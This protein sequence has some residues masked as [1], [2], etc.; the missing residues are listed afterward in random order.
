MLP[1]AVR[2]FRDI[3]ADTWA[4]LVILAVHP[5]VGSRLELS[6]PVSAEFCTQVCAVR[7]EHRGDCRCGCRRHGRRH[8]RWHGP[9]ER[10]GGTQHKMVAFNGR[11]HSAV[12]AAITRQPQ[13]WKHSSWCDMS[14]FADAKDAKDASGPVPCDTIA[15]YC[16]QRVNL[17]RGTAIVHIPN[18]I[19]AWIGIPCARGNNRPCANKLVEMLVQKPP[20]QLLNAQVGRVQVHALTRSPACSS[21]MQIVLPFPGHLPQPRSAPEKNRGVH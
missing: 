7:Q 12:A 1:D 17:C 18:R 2:H 5:F 19:R 10:G 15:S 11:P 20:I 8:R 3:H 9:G 13:C 6:F 4:L 21:S 16:D 14:E